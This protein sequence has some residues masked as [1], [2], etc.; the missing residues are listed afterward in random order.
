MLLAEKGGVCKM[1]GDFCCICLICLVS[2][3]NQP[4]S[5]FSEQDKAVTLQ[6]EQDDELFYYM[7]W[8]R[9]SS[10]GKIQLVTY[11]INKGLW[12]IEAPFNKSKYN[13]SRPAV[14]KSS[15]QIHSVEA[16]DSAVYY[17]AS[18]RARLKGHFSC[19][20]SPTG[21]PKEGMGRR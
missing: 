16:G 5:V 13:M 6:C 15:L 12:S 17:C 8:Y 9:Q 21:P 4:P 14:L 10:S 11:S 2:P 20:F 3:V 18:S 7:Y 1:F 19:G